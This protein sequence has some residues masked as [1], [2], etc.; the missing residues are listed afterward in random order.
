ML[1]YLLLYGIHHSNEEKKT[2]NPIAIPANVHPWRKL[3]FCHKYIITICHIESVIIVVDVDM[4]MEVKT[5]TLFFLYF[6]FLIA[7]TRT[8]IFL[9][10][11][12][13]ILSPYMLDCVY[14]YFVMELIVVYFLVYE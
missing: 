10:N 14:L 2:F 3:M 9:F 7:Y 5:A 8:F 13:V 12:R 11:V 4:K 6:L 1:L